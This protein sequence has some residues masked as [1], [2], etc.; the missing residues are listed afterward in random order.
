MLIL[1]YVP[2]RADYNTPL[3]ILPDG[4]IAEYVEKVIQEYLNNFNLNDTFTINIGS[5]LI[6]LQFRV[7]VKQKLI[8]SK[9]LSLQFNSTPLLIDEHSGRLEQYPDGFCDHSEK[10]LMCLCGWD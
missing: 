10:L 7:A 2:K 5:E 6:I 8:E 4:E 3:I 1:N 9:H